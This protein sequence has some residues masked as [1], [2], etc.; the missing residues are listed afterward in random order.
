MSSK[1]N[2]AIDFLPTGIFTLIITRINMIPVKGR[3]VINVTFELS[4]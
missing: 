4:R 1:L 3:I 2:F